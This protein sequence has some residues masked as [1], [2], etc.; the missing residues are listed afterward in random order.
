MGRFCAQRWRPPRTLE[1]AP[2]GSFK[3]STLLDDA[4]A[5]WPECGDEVGVGGG[6]GGVL[7]GVGWG[8]VGWGEVREMRL[9]RRARRLSGER[10]IAA[11]DTGGS[12]V[13]GVL[14]KPTYLP[15][16]LGA[17]SLRN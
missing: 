1:T 17:T 5:G 3:R 16:W 2:S 7:E 11:G 14:P 10:V 12:H 8:W 13:L 15:P 9:C 6:C 4:L